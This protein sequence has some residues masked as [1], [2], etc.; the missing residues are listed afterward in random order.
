MPV[1]MIEDGTIALMVGKIKRLVGLFADF[2]ERSR[3]GRAL[4]ASASAMAS[5]FAQTVHQLW[6]EV[7]GFTFLVLAGVG[8]LAGFREYGRYQ[9]GHST[10]LARL[11]LAAC[12][13]ASFAWFGLSSFWRVSRKKAKAKS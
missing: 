3:T 4:L 2:L 1:D 9:N 10:A 11:I 7:T 5:S 8:A 12:F 13:T 6:L